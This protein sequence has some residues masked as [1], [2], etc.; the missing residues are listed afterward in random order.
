MITNYFTDKAICVRENKNAYNELLP[1]N[2]R[3][4]DCRIE[5][6]SRI[7]KTKA[8]SEIICSF[9]ILSSPDEDI[10]ETDKIR[11]NGNLYTII[12]RSI[13]KGFTASHMEIYI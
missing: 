4:F 3:E 13:E 12:I 1:S 9:L 10:L 8:G 11:H 5:K 6:N 2:E 7:V